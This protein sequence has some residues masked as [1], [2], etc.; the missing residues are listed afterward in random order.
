[1]G[2]GMCIKFSFVAFIPTIILCKLGKNLKIFFRS[3][4]YIIII[5]LFFY[6][7]LGFP[8]NFV[9]IVSVIKFLF[10]QSSIS[11]PP[12][13]E[14]ISK[15]IELLYR[16]LKYVVPITIILTLLFAQVDEKR[17]LLIKFDKKNTTWLIILLILP[18]LLLFYQN[19]V[20]HVGFGA[21]NHY[22]LPYESYLLSICCLVTVYFKKYLKSRNP[23]F[24][25]KFFNSPVLFILVLSYFFSPGI[26]QKINLNSWTEYN[27][28]KEYLKTAKIIQALD[29]GD[30]TFLKT[31]YSTDIGLKNKVRTISKKNITRFLNSKEKNDRNL[32]WH[33]FK[34]GNAFIVGLHA[35]VVFVVLI[36]QPELAW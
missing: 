2:I 4:I 22:V 32:V 28:K 12:N 5:S 36:E 17:N 8:Q 29:D 18:I 19:Y 16:D 9:G 15:W 34:F 35:V 25:N 14:S 10:F 20:H 31:A 30:T 26:P 23:K 21:T 33:F 1:M 27:S 7:L 11:I 3:A 13:L 24:Q 6:F